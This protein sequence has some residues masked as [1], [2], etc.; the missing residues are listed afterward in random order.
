MRVHSLYGVGVGPAGIRGSK[1]RPARNFV[2]SLPDDAINRV[3]L[4]FSFFFLSLSPFLRTKKNSRRRRCNF[5]DSFYDLTFT[6]MERY[7]SVFRLR[8]PVQ[9][10][11]DFA[12]ADNKHDSN[13]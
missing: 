9:L 12:R 8:A 11:I 6:D 10:T 13:Y 1:N 7:A 2:P 4:L 5:F 3:V